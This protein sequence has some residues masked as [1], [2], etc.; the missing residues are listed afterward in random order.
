MLTRVL[1]FLAVLLLA[2]AST[3]AHAHASISGPESAS[4]GFFTRNVDLLKEIP[5]LSHCCIKEK[6]TEQSEPSNRREEYL[7]AR[8][9]DARVGRFL[10]MDGFGGNGADPMSL[11]KYT[12]V[13]AN[14]V[15]GIDPSGMITLK[16]AMIVVGRLAQNSLISI[17]RTGRNVVKAAKTA[18]LIAV[19]AGI[20]AAVGVAKLCRRNP[21][22]CPLDV[23]LHVVGTSHIEHATH[24]HDSQ[25]L[26][27]E[28]TNLIPSFFLTYRNG[29][30]RRNG[31]YPRYR[32]C[33]GV[34]PGKACDEFPYASTFQGGPAGGAAMIVSN[35]WVSLA[36]S[37]RQGNAL[38]VFYQ[39]CDERG[40]GRKWRRGMFGDS[41]ITLGI[42]EEPFTFSWCDGRFRIHP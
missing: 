38:G 6:S 39:M 15:M 34:S 5:D 8:Y 37:N 12:Y 40:S 20:A 35:K 36:E 2:T 27:G 4:L 33:N 29:Q 13:H 25:W 23:P 32:K 41:F 3:T 7:R 26:T 21:D 30:G 22:K 18:A 19:R 16:E 10:G 24:I 31:D 11:H 17:A 1:T 42:P 14:P 9:M 28:H